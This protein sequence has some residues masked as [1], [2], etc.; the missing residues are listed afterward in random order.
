MPSRQPA[1]PPMLQ[2]PLNSFASRRAINDGLF[3]RVPYTEST[4]LLRYQNEKEEE[5]IKKWFDENIWNFYRVQIY[6]EL[7][8]SSL[9]PL[10]LPSTSP[11]AIAKMMTMRVTLKYEATLPTT[12]LSSGSRSWGQQFLPGPA[13]I[14]FFPDSPPLL[15]V[16]ASQARLL[17]VLGLSR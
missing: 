13:M 6:A 17:T 8:M 7:L 16:R 10:H 2:L 15:L 12:T 14:G 11:L 4:R 1:T 5:K 9:R 3:A